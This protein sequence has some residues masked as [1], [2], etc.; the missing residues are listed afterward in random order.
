MLKITPPE[1]MLMKNYIEEHCGIH[2]EKDK[3][4]LIESRL[5]ALAEKTGCKSFQEFHFKAR[6]DPTGI[7]RDEIV[8]A[9]T[10]NETSWFRDKS[11]WEYIET[12]EVPKILN[13]ADKMGRAAIWSAAASTGQEAYSLIM[14]LYEQAMAK[15][16]PALLDN[17]EILATDIS[18]SAL[19]AAI[20][21]RYDSISINRGLSEERRER[22]FT[23]QGNVWVFDADLK[24]RVQFRKYNLQNAFTFPYLFDLILCRYVSIYFS[25]SFKRELFSKLSH[26]LRPGGVLILGATESLREYNRDFDISYYK[27]AV[28]N[29]KKIINQAISSTRPLPARFADPK[30]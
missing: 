2:L 10:T 15:G 30:I 11:L 3:E 7:L 29:T 13:Q 16:R 5:S 22:F 12:I 23:R 1:Y 26:A 17:I 24:R 18:S 9:M 4:Y 21:A 8:D 20:S 19:L 28:I 6:T 25:D 27:S 14:L